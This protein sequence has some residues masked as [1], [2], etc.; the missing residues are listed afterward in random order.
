MIVSKRKKNIAATEVVFIQLLSYNG[1]SK[2]K[3]K[4]ENTEYHDM[5]ISFKNHL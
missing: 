5:F 1:V 4:N 3:N 2:Q